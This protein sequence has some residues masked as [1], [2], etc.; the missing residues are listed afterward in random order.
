[1]S[2]SCPQ[3]PGPWECCDLRPAHLPC[4][5]GSLPSWGGGDGEGC[6]HLSSRKPSCFVETPLWM[7]LIGQGLTKHAPLGRPQEKE[8]FLPLRLLLPGRLRKQAPEW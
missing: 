8:L 7:G 3:A 4:S 6:R 1:M 5:V 2:I